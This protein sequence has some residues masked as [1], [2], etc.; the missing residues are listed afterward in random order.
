MNIDKLKGMRV[1][2]GLTQERI[3]KHIKMTITTYNRKELGLVQ[4]TNQEILSVATILNMTLQDV[5][6]VFFDSKLTERLTN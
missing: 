1:S 5:N 2:K 3:S 6:E 4:F